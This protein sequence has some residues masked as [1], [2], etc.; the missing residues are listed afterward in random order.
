MIHIKHKYF[1]E[2][3]A[4]CYPPVIIQNTVSVVSKWKQLAAKY[5]L[6]RDEQDRMSPAFRT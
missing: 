1:R 5:K 3:A 6:S 2:F 4:L